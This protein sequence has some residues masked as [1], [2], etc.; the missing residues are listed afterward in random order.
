MCPAVSVSCG[1]T[2]GIL[3]PGPITATKS[4]VAL[5]GV[6]RVLFRTILATDTKL[7]DYEV[8]NGTNSRFTCQWVSGAPGQPRIGGRATDA[9]SQK[10]LTSPFVFQTGLWY[11]VVGSIDYANSAGAVYVN[12]VLTVAGALSG[13]FDAPITANTDSR[14][15][16][17]GVRPNETQGM[18]GLI[19][20]FRLYN[21]LLGTA[22]V[23][24]LYSTYGK[25]GM[26][27]GLQHDYPLNDMAPD[28]AVTSVACIAEPERI[29]GTP[30]GSPL[31]DVGLLA[32]QKYYQQTTGRV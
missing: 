32:P 21:R 12:G 5:T 20:D 24:T 27:E 30:I 9:E 26:L 11:H 6:C 8:S 23:E 3:I 14:N 7:W 29:I 1:S 28:I 16:G 31:F 2:T 10:T 22:E 4:Q 19:E 13:T 25:D 18:D 15:G 17:I